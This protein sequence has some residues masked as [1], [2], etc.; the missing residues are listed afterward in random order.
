[1]TQTDDRP[2]EQRLAETMRARVDGLSPEDLRPLAVPAGP[3]RRRWAALAAAAVV[4]AMIGVPL[5]MQLRPSHGPGP[6]HKPADPVVD[7][8]QADVVGD[9]EPESIALGRNGSV[10]V[11]TA[12]SEPLTAKVPAGSTLVGV[13][14]PD[15]LHAVLVLTEPAQ[16]TGSQLRV[17]SVLAGGID[18]VTLNPPEALADGSVVW[19]EAG[20]VYVARAPTAAGPAD[21]VTYRPA[22]GGTWNGALQASARQGWCWDPTSEP[23]PSRCLPVSARDLD[24]DGTSDQ[25][26]FDGARLTVELSSTPEPLQALVNPGSELLGV[27]DL[28]ATTRGIVVLERAP[29]SPGVRE[30][31]VFV[32][33]GD[34]LVEP[35]RKGV[36]WLQ[37]F[38]T[39][40][41]WAADSRAYFGILADGPGGTSTME[42]SWALALT[43]QGSLTLRSTG[44]RCWDDAANLPVACR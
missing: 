21:V 18:D 34:R 9:W 12:A 31:R 3:V 24:Q 27:V 22:I 44:P 13:A 41:M 8:L 10:T 29:G 23:H 6:G 35:P 33:R 2:L 39:Y 38:G 37:V 4:A 40:R 43:S 30:A 32:V 7:R 14:R 16:G 20:S 36:L 25:V 15:G 5:A 17:L 11:Q 19:I 28:T 42:R 1:M 26:T